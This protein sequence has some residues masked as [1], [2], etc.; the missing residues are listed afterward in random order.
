M[1]KKSVNTELLWEIA[2]RIKAL[3]EDKNITQEVFYNDT[4]IHI[5]RIERAQRNISITTL[6]QICDYLEVDLATFFDGIGKN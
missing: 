3:R 5:G 4:N 1:G 2:A 6:S